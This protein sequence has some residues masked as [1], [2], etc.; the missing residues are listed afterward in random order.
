MSFAEMKMLRWMSGVS[1]KDRKKKK[2]VRGIIDVASI[3]DKMKENRIKWFGD[4]M[5]REKTKA[6]RAVMK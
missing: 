4:V 6:V 5:R 3:E 1:R 2:Y